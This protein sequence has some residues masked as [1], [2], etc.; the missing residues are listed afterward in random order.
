MNYIWVFIGGG[1]G[2]IARYELGQKVAR[3]TGSGFPFGTISVNI[4]SCLILG[5]VGYLF[6]VKGM[7]G[8]T[9]RLL[10]G[11]GFCGGFSTFSSFTAE[12]FE[13]MK[14]GQYFYAGSNIIISIVL[15]LFS[16]WAGASV[17][18]LFS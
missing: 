6:T 4:L 17:S 1:L 14:S 8:Q 16:F 2:S 10:L 11:I 18:K 12:T 13:L 7:M 5:L 3:L 9:A 15:C